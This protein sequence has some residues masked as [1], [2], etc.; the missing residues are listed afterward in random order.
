MWIVF[1]HKTNQNYLKCIFRHIGLRLWAN[2]NRVVKMYIIVFNGKNLSALKHSQVPLVVCCGNSFNSAAY[3]HCIAKTVKVNLNIKFHPSHGLFIHY[4]II[5]ATVFIY[6][7]ES[8]WEKMTAADLGGDQCIH[9]SY[10]DT[11]AAEASQPISGVKWGIK[12]P[13]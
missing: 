13:R 6:L 8:D 11:A 3:F 9:C 2:Y 10:P 1:N 5:T 4:M 12:W 7:P